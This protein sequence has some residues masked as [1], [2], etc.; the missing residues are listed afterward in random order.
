MSRIALRTALASALLALPMMGIEAHAGE[1]ILVG[2]FSSP[3]TKLR[4][5]AAEYLRCRNRLDDPFQCAANDRFWQER[6]LYR[7]LDRGRQAILKK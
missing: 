5:P 7:N 2:G 4:P 3:I 6:D 1:R